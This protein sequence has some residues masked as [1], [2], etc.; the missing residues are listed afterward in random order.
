MVRLIITVVAGSAEESTGQVEAF[1][2]LMKLT[3]IENG[4][5]GCW[6]RTDGDE[7]FTLHYEEEWATE[8]AMRRRVRSNRFTSLLSLL[9]TAAE[10]PQ[11]QFD[12]ITTTSGL[13]YVAAV[14]D[15][16]W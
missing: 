6:V 4:C 8:D 11:V 9:E 14:R 7:K 2:S 12:F 13:E 3:R 16:A 1:Q 5:L 15:Q 10:P